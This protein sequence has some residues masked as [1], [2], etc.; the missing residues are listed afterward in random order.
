MDQRHAEKC[1]MW[2]LVQIWKQTIARVVGGDRQVDRLLPLAD[3]ADDS[4]GAPDAE[5]AHL[6]RVQSIGGHEDEV[7]A[8]CIDEIDRAGV[9]LHRLNATNDNREGLIAVGRRAHLLDNAPQ[10]LK[11]S[12]TPPGVVR[13]HP[14]RSRRLVD[15]RRRSASPRW[16]G[17]PV[18]VGGIEPCQMMIANQGAAPERRRP[19][20]R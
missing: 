13:L 19:P 18:K 6:R 14:K 2:G 10:D 11:H 17:Y 15:R 12:A 16:S 1:A 3:E 20:R 7:A 9:D 8:C 4:L 5:H